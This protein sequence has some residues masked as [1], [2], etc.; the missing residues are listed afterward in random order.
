[1][2]LRIFKVIIILSMLILTGCSEE[3]SFDS[4]NSYSILSEI[5]ENVIVNG[6]PKYEEVYIFKDI[7]SY[8][9]YYE[10]FFQIYSEIFVPDELDFSKVNLLLHNTVLNDGDRGAVYSI[11]KITKRNNKIKVYVKAD[12]KVQ[13]SNYVN[14]RYYNRSHLIII[15]KSLVPENSE[16]IVIRKENDNIGVTIN[17][18]AK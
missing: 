1:M 4:D 3:I 8:K 13:V 6:K 2:K 7:E 9:K 14:S 18:I 10:E 5:K 16:I 11:E 15:D 17:Q 12:A